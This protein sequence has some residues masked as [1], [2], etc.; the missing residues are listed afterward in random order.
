[1]AS[2]WVKLPGAW[3]VLHLHRQ[4]AAVQ[5]IADQL[6]L[7][8]QAELLHEMDAVGLHRAGADAQGG[9]YFRIC[10]PFGGQVQDLTLPRRQSLIQ[11]LHAWQGTVTL[12][13]NETFSQGSAERETPGSDITHVVGKVADLVLC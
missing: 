8:A 1:M 6:G 10:P 9:R 2:L 3:H 12:D 13:R 11:V 4:D 5:G 7:G